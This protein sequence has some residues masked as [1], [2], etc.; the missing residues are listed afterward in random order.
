LEPLL[1]GVVAALGVIL[2]LLM[3]VGIGAIVRTV[4]TGRAARPLLQ[5]GSASAH[6]LKPTWL[7]GYRG[8]HNGFEVKVHA[9]TGARGPVVLVDGLPAGISVLPEDASVR[10][11]KAVLGGL[12]QDVHLGDPAVDDRFVFTGRSWIVYSS[13]SAEAREALLAAARCAPDVRV[14]LGTLRL[15]L[16]ME[17]GGDEVLA[18]VAVASTLARALTPEGGWNAG[19]LRACEDPLPAVREGAARALMVDARGALRGEYARRLLGNTD[20]RVRLQG[21]LAL[22]PEGQGTLLELARSDIHAVRAEAVA[23]VSSDA[24]GAESAACVAM[25][26]EMLS[27][28]LAGAALAERLGAAGPQVEGALLTLLSRPEREAELAAIDALAASGTAR[29]VPALT[30]LADGLMFG[31]VRREARRAVAEVQAR[32]S[33][34]RGALTLAGPASGGAVSLTGQGEQGAVSLTRGQ[35]T[36]EKEA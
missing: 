30:A 24:P 28:A 23:A 8:R 25:A 26:D 5:A 11:G 17:A 22:G 6:G 1:A 29:S 36:G 19:L 34:E 15:Q 31:P 33:G 16:G 21:A 20:D 3:I 9:A 2:P 35:V 32:A 27:V 7:G 10:L 12:V 13:L 18:A 14:Q 4:L